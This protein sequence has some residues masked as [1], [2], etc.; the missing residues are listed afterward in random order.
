MKTAEEIR[1]EIM[2]IEDKAYNM[3]YYEQKLRSAKDCQR[4]QVA[5]VKDIHALLESYAEQ[6]AKEQRDDTLKKIFK[7]DKFR[8][9]Y[10]SQSALVTNK[11]QP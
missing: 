5:K 6:V 10:Y 4:I 8:I 3:M 9:A 7:N 1:I 2:N 11:Q